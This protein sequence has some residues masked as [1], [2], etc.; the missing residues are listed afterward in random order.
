MNQKARRIDF[1]VFPLNAKS[2][3]IGLHSTVRPF[4]AH[5]QV[6]I[7]F[8]SATVILPSPPAQHLG[9][10]G[11]GLKDAGRRRGDEYFG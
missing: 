11:D 9:W 5:A 4:S 3:A 10:V 1:E 8:L 7:A 6:G 2:R